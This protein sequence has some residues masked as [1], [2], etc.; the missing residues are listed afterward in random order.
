VGQTSPS[1]IVKVTNVST[2]LV[3]FT[4]F[5]LGGVATGDYLITNNTCGASLAGGASCAVSVALKPTVKGT[6]TAMLKV[7]D[8]GGGSPQTAKL[9]GVGG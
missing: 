6:R 4:S 5:T 8:N 7:A 9:T 3:T 1:Q 2:F